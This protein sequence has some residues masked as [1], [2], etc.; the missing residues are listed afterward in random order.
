MRAIRQPPAVP[1]RDGPVLR[2]EQAEERVHE[3]AQ[4]EPEGGL[5]VAGRHRLSRPYR[6]GA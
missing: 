6:S 5:L 4:Q 1:E 2:V 3:H